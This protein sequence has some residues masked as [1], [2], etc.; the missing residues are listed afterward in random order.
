ML[1]HWHAQDRELTLHQLGTDPV[2][3]LEPGESTRR[4]R[5]HGPNLVAGTAGRSGDRVPSRG[6]GGA[7]V[8]VL[9]A[10]AAACLRAGAT[11]EAAAVA[12]GALATWLLGVLAAPRRAGDPDAVA[13]AAA[14]SARVVRGGRTFIVP[15]ADL[16]AGDLAVLAAGERVPA[17]LR[18]L[19]ARGLL[20]D[21]SGLT[22]EPLPAAKDPAVVLPAGTPLAER[23]NLAHAG[24]LVT[25]GSGK[26][27][28]V[29]TGARSELGAVARLHAGAQP[30][31]SPLAASLAGLGT[32]A[33]A[34]ALPL[35]AATFAL[36]RLRGEP[37]AAAALTAAGL[38]VAAV[39]AGVPAVVLAALGLGARRLARGGASL[40]ERTAADTA[41]A[42]AVLATEAT[43]VLTRGELTVRELHLEGRSLEVTG[44]GYS[45]GG[46]IRDGDLRAD[47]ERWGTLGIA[48]RV[49]AL[50]SHATLRRD[51]PGGAWQAEG[52]PTDAALL[53]LAAK[54]GVLREGLLAAGGVVGELPYSAERR[55]VTVLA[56]AGGGRPSAHTCG[57][58]EVVLAHCLH[59]RTPAGVRPL[60]P[61]DRE[62]ILREA[63][64]MRQRSLRTL[65]LAYRDDVAGL[66]SAKVER[67]MVWVG[68]AGATD[69]PRDEAAADLA[70]CREAGVRPVVLTGAAPE[71]AR[72]IAG[73]VGVLGPG[74]EAITGDELDALTPEALAASVDRYGLFAR[75][76][77]AHKLKIVRAWRRRGRVV[78]VNT[79][80]AS[81]APAGREADLAVSVGPRRAGEATGAVDLTASGEGLGGV[82][83]A[84]LESRRVAGGVRAAVAHVVTCSFAAAALLLA[85]AVGGLPAPLLPRQALWLAV[86]VAPPTALLLA[87]APL[88]APA[89]GVPGRRRR[90]RLAVPAGMAPV[91]LEGG[92]MALAALA[93]F[94]LA[95]GA[96]PDPGAARTSALATL[97]VAQLLAALVR[98]RGPATAFAASGALVAGAPVLG[99]LLLVGA[100]ALPGVGPVFGT[101]PLAAGEWGRAIALG[102]ATL[103]AA[104]LLRS[105]LVPGGSGEG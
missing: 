83:A 5:E 29:A 69:P 101:V 18:L 24:G 60:S 25:A 65:G 86:A 26:G 58:P 76:T 9:L 84:I 50:C 59:H 62:R 102:L 90:R 14:A 78:A 8:L 49:A 88:A 20:V 43:G 52:D 70:A 45:T 30:D 23:A 103:P 85:A 31:P 22:G 17:D 67:A 64:A 80:G 95:R 46:E 72:A 27:V 12:A 38:A 42:V 16:V 79:L 63:A 89:L 97:G 93:A 91:A 57:E 74:E 10:A 56:V 2:R 77:A 34:V 47:P 36:G 21:E 1:N 61:G 105:R 73:E 7:P 55:R 3:G 53:C 40:G 48:L 37:L 13:R 100:I 44:R 28:V 41:A 98:M 81:D 54:G 96:S 82:L 39:P 71:R 4:L 75:V 11:G 92:A 6:F 94:L 87:A 15:A 104:W 68:L 33:A 32:T 99:A 35:A 66:E 19:A 51:G